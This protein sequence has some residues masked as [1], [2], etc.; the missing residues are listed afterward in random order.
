MFDCRRFSSY[1]SLTLLLASLPGCAGTPRYSKAGAYAV[2]PSYEDVKPEPRVKP[3]PAKHALEGVASYY[4]KEFHGRRTANG[5]KLDINDRTAAHRTLPFGT[6]VRVT[7]V[8]S[9]KSVEVRIND[10]GPFQKNR[11]IDLTPAAAQKIGLDV[12][13]LLKV[14]IEILE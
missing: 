4:G 8:E 13:G 12:Q 11:V 6:W 2:R 10:R 9:E 5:E 3:D 14:R 1:A 7:A